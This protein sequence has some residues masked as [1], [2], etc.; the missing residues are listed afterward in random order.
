VAGHDRD[1]GLAIESAHEA[2]DLADRLESTLAQRKLRTLIG[3]LA[4]YG[5]SL[6]VSELLPRLH[7]E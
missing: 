1:I 4:P 5:A 3:L 6:A 2:V 7:L